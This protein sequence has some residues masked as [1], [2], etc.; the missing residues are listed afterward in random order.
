MAEDKEWTAEEDAKLKEMKAQ[1]KTWK[2]IEGE[3]GRPKYQLQARFKQI[4]DTNDGGEA[5]KKKDNGG[6]K[7][8]K[9]KDKGGEKADKKK[10]EGGIDKAGGGGEGNKQ[11]KQEKKSKQEKKQEKK[12][13]TKEA[14]GA[15]AASKSGSRR[16]T[17]F[18]MQEWTT[19]QED[20][21]FTFGELQLLTE[22]VKRDQD[23]FWLRIAANFYDKTGRRV[24]PDDVREKF[25]QMDRLLG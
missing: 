12:Q 11:D 6:D 3:M 14:T 25:E 9:K 23:L 4:K 5:D 16:E 24:H 10:D 19:L 21:L 13:A 22:L 8:D 20:E 7:A 2:E 15:K 17:K 18:T 1:N